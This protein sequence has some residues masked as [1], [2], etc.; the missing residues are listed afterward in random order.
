MV[1]KDTQFFK[2]TN[3]FVKISNISSVEISKS[4]LNFKPKVTIAIPTY[5]RAPLLK[6]AID[7][8]INQVGYEFYDIIVV[9]N[10]PIRGCETEILMNTFNNK[11]ISYFKNSKN[12]GMAGNWNRLFE[13]AKGEFVVMLHDDDLLLPSFLKTTIMILEKNKQ[14][15]IL[16]PKFSIFY[17]KFENKNF[18]LPIDSKKLNKIYPFSFY[19]GN[20]IGAPVGVVFKKINFL[21]FGGF[22]QDF[23]PSMDYCFFVYY[24]KYFNIYNYDECLSLYRYSINESLKNETL[25][26]FIRVD[27]FL[28]STLLR[29]YFIPRLII[30]NYLSFK[31]EKTIRLYK[32]SVNTNF[33]FDDKSL[34]WIKTNNL[35]FGF[36]SAIILFII[37]KI[38]KF[39]G[40]I[41]R[42]IVLK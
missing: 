30:K 9:D 32:T 38:I 2:I 11:R 41:I 23:Y 40:L 22:N 24:S 28:V 16:K 6:E 1:N 14:I 34:G 26:N 36:L 10:D 4:N 27:Y 35:I 25:N 37:D 3:N 13:L 17:E 15:D 19:K 18:V 31:L 42:F 12:I 7:S 29:K 33:I 39:N 8:A 20:V 5:K 21:N